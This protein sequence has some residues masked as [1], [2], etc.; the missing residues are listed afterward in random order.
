MI[1]P[2]SSLERFPGSKGG[3]PAPAN[4]FCSGNPLGEALAG[5]QQF[6]GKI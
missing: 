2:Q 4:K 5:D 1:D 6:C 3:F